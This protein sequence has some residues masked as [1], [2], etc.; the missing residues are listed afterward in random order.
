MIQ[1]LILIGE[2]K[3]YQTGNGEEKKQNKKVEPDG[4]CWSRRKVLINPSN[5]RYLKPKRNDNNE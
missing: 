4:V 3:D 5:P 2:H 1:F